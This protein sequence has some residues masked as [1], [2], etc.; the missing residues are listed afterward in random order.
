MQQT[1]HHAFQRGAFVVCRRGYGKLHK[2]RSVRQIDGM[3]E[4]VDQAP[5]IIIILFIGAS[6]ELFQHKE[7][8]ATFA[9]PRRREPP[10]DAD[11]QLLTAEKGT[12]RCGVIRIRDVLG[13]RRPDCCAVPQETACCCKLDKFRPMRYNADM[14]ILLLYL[15]VVNLAAF[16]LMAADKRRARLHRWRIPERTLFAAALLG[17]SLGA[18]AGM[19]L[20]RHKTK[21][22]YFV[23]GMPLILAVQ[24]AAC[25]WLA[26][27]QGV[28]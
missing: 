12:V 23:L 4:G 1:E 16:G 21:H 28:V 3:D 6:A 5:L 22:W 13:R 24:V 25:V 26:G 10:I 2:S 11:G 14:K 9:E 27:E 19:V 8:L 17:G 7:R 15:A 18:I 20:C